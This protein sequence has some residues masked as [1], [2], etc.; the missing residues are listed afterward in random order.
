[1]D[2]LREIPSYSLVRVVGGVGSSAG[3]QS[4]YEQMADLKYQ[5]ADLWDD[6]SWAET[7]EE[8]EKLLGQEGTLQK[9]SAEL[10]QQLRGG[11]SQSQQTEAA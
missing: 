4:L 7:D 10:F 3:G 9:R 5:Q 11:S 8:R 1:M 6:I 2:P